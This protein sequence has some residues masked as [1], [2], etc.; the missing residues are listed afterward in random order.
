MDDVRENEMLH[1]ENSEL[2]YT[3]RALLAQLDEARAAL[4]KAT[5]SEPFILND[6]LQHL[7]T[8]NHYMTEELTRLRAERKA[9]A[10]DLAEAR[11]D[12][13]RFEAALVEIRGICTAMMDGWGQTVTVLDK[14]RKI[15]LAAIKRQPGEPAH[16]PE[17]FA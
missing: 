8:S 5:K 13:Q 17:T 3:N 9:E 12:V 2:R 7:R 11:A 14:I 10:K 1:I 4:D 15:T 6:E 16:R